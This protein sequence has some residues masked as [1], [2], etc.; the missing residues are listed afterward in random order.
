MF[1]LIWQNV[2][3]VR[4]KNVRVAYLKHKEYHSDQ[5]FITKDFS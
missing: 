4:L 3:N 5:C 2:L 1:H